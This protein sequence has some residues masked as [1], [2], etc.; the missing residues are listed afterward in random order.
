MTDNDLP[1]FEPE[2]AGLVRPYVITG[3]RDLPAEDEFS[4]IT[5]VTTASDQ[6]QRPHRLSPE[7][8][9]LLAMCAGGYLS[10]AEI[11]GHAKLPLGVLKV[12][13]SSLSEGGYLLTRAPVPQAR[14]AGAD[15]LQEVLD[16][17]RTHFG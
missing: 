15:L 8:Q 2:A 7:E 17:L 4:L 16:G 14:S 6:R 1:E 5:L 11:A 3:G 12:L 9:Q 13:L 10:V